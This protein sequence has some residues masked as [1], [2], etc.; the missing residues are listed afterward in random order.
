MFPTLVSAVKVKTRAPVDTQGLRD[1]EDQGRFD[2]ES[3]IF[4]E[5]R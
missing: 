1:E 5:L 2:W 3:G 4:A